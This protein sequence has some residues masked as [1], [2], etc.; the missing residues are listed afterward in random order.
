VFVK[1]VKVQNKVDRPGIL[2]GTE[3]NIQSNAQPNMYGEGIQT[4]MTAVACD[5]I[6]AYSTSVN[7]S[8]S[9]FTLADND[10]IFLQSSADRFRWRSRKDFFTRERDSACDLARERQIT[11]DTDDEETSC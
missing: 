3:A 10:S 11:F 2:D 7:P 1:R 5:R 9:S 8:C 6:R 4:C